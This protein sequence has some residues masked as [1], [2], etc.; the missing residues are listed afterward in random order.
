MRPDAHRDLK[1]FGGI[2]L[3]SVTLRGAERDRLLARLRLERAL[4]AVDWTPRGLP[5]GA[6]LLVRRLVATRGVR[7]TLAR[8]VTQALHEHS[9]NA[10]R[11]WLDEQA[12]DAGAVWFDRGELAACLA[13]DA[14]RGRVSQR[15]WWPGVL[16]GRDPEQWL[17]EHV[18]DHG[19]RVVSLLAM[20]CARD[21]AV[22]WLRRLSDPDAARGLDAVIRDYAVP[23]VEYPTRKPHSP[24]LDKRT[25][26]V[27]PGMPDPGIATTA[28]TAKASKTAVA[29]TA[30]VSNSLSASPRAV[31]RLL[32][33]A[34]E[35]LSAR[36]AAPA[37]RLLAHARVAMHDPNWLRSREF[38]DTLNRWIDSQAVTGIEPAAPERHESAIGTIREIRPGV[39]APVRIIDTSEALVAGSSRTHQPVAPDRK[40]LRRF[41]DT[42]A[43]SR[44]IATET[45]LPATSTHAELPAAA[46]ALD[47]QDR[48]EPTA[49]VYATDMDAAETGIIPSPILDPAT[50]IDDSPTPSPA[51]AVG[52]EYTAHAIDT[53]FGGLLYL[54]NVALA[55]ELYG[56][57]TSPRTPGIALSP[58]DWLAMIA[59]AWFGASFRNDPLDAVLAKLAGRG[60]HQSPGADFDPGRD[61]SMPNA[62]LR[63]W[64]EIDRLGYRADADRLRIWHPQGFVVFDQPRDRGLSPAVQAANLCATRDHLRGATLQRMARSLSPGRSRQTAQRWLDRLL[65]YLHA[66]IALALGLDAHDAELPAQVCRHRARVRCDLTHLDVHLSLASLP[67]S[68]RIAG[69]DRDPGWI[70]AAGRS[71]RF[72]FDA[73][74]FD[75]VGFDTISSDRA[76]RVGDRA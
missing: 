36:L 42:P 53:E 10:R 56:D 60:A 46:S 64:G 28:S 21:D 40:A 33:A 17:R 48:I 5:A 65:P 52:D 22:A 72:H 13:R 20:L 69:L 29:H 70:P 38:V 74:G 59:R 4:D 54:L 63:P 55:L 58:W 32:A 49:A 15:W 23:L 76:D 34:P 7:T 51:E 12:V 75:S 8:T 62:W 39:S 37:Q 30:Q 3:R 14:L 47:A 9:R 57:F 27:A 44:V 11:P 26:D 71:I 73:A 31:A 19:E 43:Q 16:E 68:L 2:R 18:L 1:Q 61:A 24:D 25:I 45:D 50:Q 67:L 6:V 66:R 41:P 35:L